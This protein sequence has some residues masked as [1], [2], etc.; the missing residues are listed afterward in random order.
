LKQQTFPFLRSDEPITYTNLKT[1]LD[2]LYAEQ[3]PPL[4]LKVIAAL[5][6]LETSLV[7]RVKAHALRELNEQSLELEALDGRW[8]EFS[9][10]VFEESTS[11]GKYDKIR[12]RLSFDTTT[13]RMIAVNG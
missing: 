13:Q 2:E 1:Q 10:V 3:G 5:H 11:R 8:S 12:I 9:Q 6:R 7:D 4:V